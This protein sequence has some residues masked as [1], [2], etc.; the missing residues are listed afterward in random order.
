M[1]VACL[2]LGAAAAAVLVLPQA[3]AAQQFFLAFGDSITF[4][5]GD[6]LNAG[7]Y[8]ARLQTL[9]DRRGISSVVQNA[10]QSGETTAQG[11]TRID[12]ALPPRA[13]TLLLME[14]TNDINVKISTETIA[15]N[16]D[17]I[18]RKAESQGY[19]VV[20][21]TVPPRLP[22]ASVDGENQQ[23]AGLAAA[24]RELAWRQGRSL[25][26]PFEVFF[27]YT[28][29]AFSHDYLGG[30]DNLHPNA[31]GYDI[32]AATFADVLSGADKV[33]PV[34]GLV[35][36][37]PART[38]VP[39]NTEIDVDL[40][41]FGKGIDLRATTLSINGQAVSPS[42]TGNSSKLQMVF[43]PQTPLKGLVAVHLTSQ[44]LASPPNV[45]DRDVTD[46]LV[47]GTVFLPG[48]INRDGRV[49]GADLILLALAFGAHRFDDRYNLAADLNGDG[50]VD[51]LDLAILASN[52]G[53]SSF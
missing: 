38:D 14:G 46:F 13:G 17:L 32:L 39:A 44:D 43:R 29:D 47:A 50:I 41:D 1:A 52:F 9:L 48:D 5:V 24:I 49:D 34:T 42:V 51:G 25:A 10:G 16:L 31:A 18:A 26:D 3:A 22:A 6:G 53:K 28:P 8:P 35:Y 36:P 21:A 7:G 23:T 11:L 45:I 30:A 15:T 33:P 4:G 40:Y 12:L 37:P 27:Y 2:A 20:H 19:K